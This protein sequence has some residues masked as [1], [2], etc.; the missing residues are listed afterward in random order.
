MDRQRARSAS[1]GFCSP[2]LALRAHPAGLV[3]P[4]LSRE[5]PMQAAIEGTREIGLAV[6]ATTLSAADA[7]G[8]AVLYSLLDDFARLFRQPASE[9]ATFLD[10][11]TSCRTSPP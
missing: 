10:R 8:G 5:T 6:L 2:W 11:T 9:D 3:A 7:V 1:K 4:R